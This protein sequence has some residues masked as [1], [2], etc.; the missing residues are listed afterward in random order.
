M[1]R[2]GESYQAASVHVP[3]RSAVATDSGTTPKGLG[4][5]REKGNRLLTLSDDLRA[6]GVVEVDVD[7][8]PFEVHDGRDLEWYASD[9]EVE[10]GDCSRECLAHGEAR[11]LVTFA[12]GETVFTGA[13]VSFEVEEGGLSETLKIDDYWEESEV[14]PEGVPALS[15]IQDAVFETS[16]FR[17]ALKELRFE[18]T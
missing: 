5:E 14:T 3:S 2:T 17:N 8:F 16:S 15:E 6:M 1:A 13:V 4:P 7:I 10:D 11:V 12:T 18:E 9:D